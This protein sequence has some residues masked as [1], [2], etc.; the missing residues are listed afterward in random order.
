VTQAPPPG[1]R[2]DATGDSHQPVAATRGGPLG[3]PGFRRYLLGFGASLAADGL[4][5]VALGWAAARLGDPVQA[6]L[7]MAAGSLPRAALLLVGGTVADRVGAF[8]MVIRT[9][10][11]R[12]AVMAAF[13]VVAF[14]TTPTALV[15]GAVAAVFGLLDAL[16]LPA[17]AAL[18]PTLLSSRDLP[19]GQ[20]LV[21]TLERLAMVGATGLGGLL[22]AA[23]GLPAAALG[24]TILLGV[25]VPA[26]ASLRRPEQ[27][28]ETASVTSE[29]EPSGFLRN[30][31]EGL[32]FAARHGVIG[33]ILLVVTIVNF[34]LMPPL[35]I[36][37]P[38]VAGARGWTATTYGLLLAVFSAGAAVGSLSVLAWRPRRPA[39][40]ALCWIVLGTACLALLGMVTH[41]AAA[42]AAAT[43]LGLSSGPSSALLLG[44]VQSRTP[45]RHMG[46]VMAL[47]A[48]S[49]LG[50]T[51]VGYAT[52]GALADVI[53]TGQ[54]F[55]VFAAAGLAV[56]LFAATR[57]QLRR[58]TI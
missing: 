3:L 44:L 42:A 53:G 30:A 15:L 48:F 17:T 58:A 6:S 39:L 23:R 25:A 27:A 46:K 21:Q 35:N 26:L 12:L 4:W 55:Q 56:A 10:N 19:A 43:L 14:A 50:L 40:A 7:V 38:L 13:T 2:L 34:T 31:V 5:F 20:G 1:G 29:D 51:P 8:T 45:T 47:L 32:R 22:I 37:L 52:F 9:Q 16:H 36:G 54:A 28:V 24:A 57:P 33:P 18:P 41:V 49:A 11:L